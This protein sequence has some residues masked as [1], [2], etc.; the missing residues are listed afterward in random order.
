MHFES[1]LTCG[2]GSWLNCTSKELESVS[3]NNHFVSICNNDIGFI[4]DPGN[5]LGKIGGFSIMQN[6][7]EFPP[8]EE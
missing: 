7:V 1:P 2:F 3:V 6:L 8:P 5:F 4:G